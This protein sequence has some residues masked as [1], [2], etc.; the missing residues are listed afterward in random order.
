VGGAFYPQGGPFPPQYHGQYF[1]ADHVGRA[2]SR[3]D[4]INRM[5]HQQPA[6]KFKF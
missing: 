2:I 4:M 3:L 1:F 5:R 6:A